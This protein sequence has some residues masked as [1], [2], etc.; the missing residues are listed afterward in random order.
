MPLCLQ[1]TLRLCLAAQPQRNKR[2]IA[3]RGQVTKK[4]TNDLGGKNNN[5]LPKV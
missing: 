1:V 5:K 2:Y 3:K 4:K